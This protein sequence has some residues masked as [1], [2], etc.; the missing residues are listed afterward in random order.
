MPICTRCFAI[1]LGHLLIPLFFIYSIPFYIGF[2]LQIPMI[3]DGYTQLKKWRTSNHVLRFLTGIISG[4]GLS[5]VNVKINMYIF[6][7]LSM[8]KINHFL[9]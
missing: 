8:Y 4:A 7:C 3:V 2:L 9:C 1:L 5:I 6:A